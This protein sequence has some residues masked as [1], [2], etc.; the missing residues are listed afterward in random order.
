M[1]CG[2]AMVWCN[3]WV[4]RCCGS[5]NN[6]FEL[7]CITSYGPLK[8]ASYQWREDRQA[9]LI[10]IAGAA[11]VERVVLHRLCIVAVSDSLYRAWQ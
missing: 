1:V 4:D 3:G 2:W 8:L 9:I 11:G 6:D 5:V 7:P 10:A